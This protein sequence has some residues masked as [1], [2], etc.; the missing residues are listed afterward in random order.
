MSGVSLRISIR[1]KSAGIS[2]SST[3][4][5]SGFTLFPISRRPLI[6]H[7][8]VGHAAELI[9]AT[10]CFC[11]FAAALALATRLT[12]GR[13][14]WLILAMV[15]ALP[16]AYGDQVFFTAETAALPRPFAEAAVLAAIA[17]CIA[18]QRSL[19]IGFLAVGLLLHPIMALPGAAVIA[20]M[21]LRPRM[22]IAAAAMLAASCVALGFAG[23]SVFDRLFTGVDSEWLGM[24]KQLSPHLFPTEWTAKDFGLLAIAA[25][26]LVIAA[27]LIALPLR[28]LFFASLIVGLG[29]LLASTVLGDFWLNL[30]AIQIQGWRST[31]LMAVIAHFAYAL[32]VPLLWNRASPGGQAQGRATL[33]LLTLGNFISPDIGLALPISAA[34]LTLHFGRFVK[35]FAPGI[36]F[37][38]WAATAGLTL[39]FYY[40]VLDN[41]V[42]FACRSSDDMDRRDRVRLAF[43]DVFAIPL[44]AMASL[45]FWCA[46]HLRL[47]AFAG[48][49]TGLAGLCAGDMLWAFPA[50][51]QRS[52][53]RCCEI[54]RN[55]P[56]C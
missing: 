12:T 19:A 55:L 54:R 31:W 50:A 34:A 45:W 5:K 13:A 48:L 53:S 21:E 25:T 40:L 17:A 37:A 49:M 8:G 41:F 3:T 29:G 11:W 1:P 32:C 38:T 56:K 23:V 15:C 39:Y 26:T 52:I 33:A 44:C 24:L 35:P 30:L 18:R 28:R 4:V 9:G 36:A 6:A 16:S 43:G 2:C 10:A 42:R 7:L 46:P 20:I 47:P 14:V 27:D 51:V 22:L